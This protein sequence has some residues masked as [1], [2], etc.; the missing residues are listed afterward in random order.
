MSDNVADDLRR[1]IAELQ[2]ALEIAEPIDEERDSPD[3]DTW[4]T[5]RHIARAVG[6][7]DVDPCTNERS[8]IVARRTFRLD[9]GQDGLVL[10]KF[11]SRNARVWCN[12]PYSDVMP[13]I[14]AYGH[15]RFCFLVKFDPSTKWCR[16]LL[17]RANFILFPQLERMKFEAPPGVESSSNQF[18][19]GLFYANEADATADIKALCYQWRT[20]R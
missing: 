3:R 15:T 20:V 2:V 5:P 17:A 6:P 9:Q 18:P 16:E 11:V 12:P 19:H 4:V 13:W 14:I 1:R 10:A 8:H 7:W